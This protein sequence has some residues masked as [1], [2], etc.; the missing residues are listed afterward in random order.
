MTRFI[1]RVRQKLDAE[2]GK[3]GHRLLLGVRVPQTLE[4]CHALGYDVP[5]WIKEGLID[6]VADCGVFGMR[7]GWHEQNEQLDCVH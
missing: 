3:K 7:C 5:T 1:R 2:A 4:E 6:Y